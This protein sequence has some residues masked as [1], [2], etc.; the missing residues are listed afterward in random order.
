[1]VNLALWLSSFNILYA[2]DF[3]VS[4]LLTCLILWPYSRRSMGVKLLSRVLDAVYVAKRFAAL[5]LPLYMLEK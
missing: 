2:Y 1:M 4:S 5:L 3:L